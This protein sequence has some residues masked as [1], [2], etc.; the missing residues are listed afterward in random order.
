M[1]VR[2][3][4]LTAP[5]PVRTGPTASPGVLRRRAVAYREK[6]DALEKLLA[7]TQAHF[8]EA[9]AEADA[10]RSTRDRITEEAHRAKRNRSTR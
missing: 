8:G 1:P 5:P 6:A 10:Q 2:R 9:F 7:D 4:R 3:T